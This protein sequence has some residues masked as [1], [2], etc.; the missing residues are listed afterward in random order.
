MNEKQT[1]IK[2][3]RQPIASEVP[4][5]GKYEFFNSVQD[6]E[7]NVGMAGNHTQKT[8]SLALDMITSPWLEH[9]FK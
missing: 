8:L 3:N 9:I 1:N 5:M 6:I 2:R 4:Q 7:E